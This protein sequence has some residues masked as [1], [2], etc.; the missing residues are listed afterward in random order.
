MIKFALRQLL[1]SLVL[2][3][4]GTASTFLIVFS[5]S[6][7]V[8]RE[9]LGQG[10]TEETV[11]ARTAELGLD[12]PVLLQYGQWVLD[13]LRGD[14]G[15]SYY[16]GEAVVTILS[17][18]VPVTLSLVLISVLLLLIL[19]VV[20]GVTAAVRGGWIDRLLQFG[21][22]FAG[23]VPNFVIA[24]ILVFAFAVALRIFPATG[25]VSPATS[26][27]GWISTLVLPVTAV[28]VTS[29]AGAS[30][31]FR[32]AMIDTLSQDYIRTLRAR[33]LSRSAI[34]YRHALRN[35]ALP[36]LTTISLQ[37]IGLMG[38]VVIIETIFALP[39]VAAQLTDSAI[40][41]D[42]PVVMGAVLFTICVIV[43]VNI[44]LNLVTGF[45]NPKERLS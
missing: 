15:R 41:R 36:G 9:I 26:I 1:S 32:G 24:I 39:G 23:A 38:G 21:G 25:Y 31:Q 13:A 27:V 43:V 40:L 20:I 17:T 35:A 12:Q 8:V 44:V 28:L 7:N 19:S 45:V 5:N 42:I 18:R 10:A 6:G 33:G 11:R 22:I 4:V 34:I 30:L 14:L 16:T 29:V 2:L 3:V 37:T